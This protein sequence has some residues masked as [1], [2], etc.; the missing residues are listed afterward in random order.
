MRS[1]TKRSAAREWTAGAV[2]GQPFVSALA[3]GR[4]HGEEVVEDLPTRVI[5]L[6]GARGGERET[7][8]D[9]HRAR[10][11]ERRHQGCPDLMNE[12]SRA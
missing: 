1:F 6:E 7:E 3:P 2:G 9:V 10:L 4:F 5:R 12:P 8:A 11:G